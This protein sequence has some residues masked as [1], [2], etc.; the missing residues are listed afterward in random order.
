MKKMLCSAIIILMIGV[1]FTQFVSNFGRTN[2]TEDNMITGEN[3]SIFLSD[4]VDDDTSNANGAGAGKSGDKEFTRSSR[5]SDVIK[6]MFDDAHLPAFSVDPA[7]DADDVHGWGHVG[8]GGHSSF[9][10]VLRDP[11]GMEAS[12]PGH[13]FETENTYE[14]VLLNEG[15]LFTKEV[16]EDIDVL[17]VPMT[18]NGNYRTSEIDVIEDFVKNGGGLLLGADHSNFPA[19]VND[20]AMRFFVRWGSDVVTD[21]NDYTGPYNYWVIYEDNNVPGDDNMPTNDVPGY[22]NDPDQIYIITENAPTVQ[23][24]CSNAYTMEN[25]AESRKIIITDT[26]GSSNF[27]GEPACLAI[28]NGNCTGAGRAVFVPDCN[29]FG[30]TYDCDEDG[31]VDFW[32]EHNAEFGLGIIDWLAPRAYEVALISGEKDPYTGLPKPLVYIYEPGETHTFDIE[33]WNLGL[34]ADTIKLE[35]PDVPGNWTASLDVEETSELDTR[36]SEHITLTVTAPL[37]NVT[38]GDY[39]IINVT[40]TSTGDPENATD[41]IWTTN[42]IIVDLGYNVNWA[43]KPDVNEQKK[44]IVDPGKTTVATLGINNIGNINDTYKI[45]MQGVPSDWKVNVDTDHNPDWIFDE[46][47]M[48]VSNIKLSSY[49]FEENTTGVTVFI[50]PPIDAKEGETAIVTAVGESY[51]SKLS[52]QDAK[53]KHDDEIIFEVSAFRAMEIECDDAIKYVD[54][55]KS[56]TFLIS[57][58]NN[59]NSRE[60]VEIQL[61]PM[62]SGW[63]SI[64]DMPTI[65]LQ[66]RQKKTITVTMT[67]PEGA[68]EGSRCVLEVKL[69]MPSVDKVVDSVFLTTIVNRFCMISASLEDSDYYSLNAG[70][71]ISLNISVSNLGNGMTGANFYMLQLAMG[72]DFD[73][74]SEGLPVDYITLEP[75]QS[76][77]LRLDITVSTKALADGIPETPGFDPYPVIINISGEENF[78]YLFLSILV[79]RKSSIEVFSSKDLEI[80]EPGAFTLFRVCVRNDGNAWDEIQLNIKDIPL[81]IHPVTEMRKPWTVFFSGVSLDEQMSGIKDFE[82]TDFTQIVDVAKLDHSTAFEPS[83]MREE[84][85]ILNE[86]TLRIPMKGAAWVTLTVEVPRYA[87]ARDASFNISSFCISSPGLKLPVIRSTVSVRNA[88]LTFVGGIEL[89]ETI[90]TGQLVSVM[91]SVKNTGDIRAEDVQVRLYVDGQ[92]VATMPIRTILAGNTQMVAF[93]WKVPDISECRLKVVVD[94]DNLIVEKDK[95]DNSIEEDV[96]IEGSSGVMS[97]I[98]KWVMAT[99]GIIVLGAVLTLALMWSIRK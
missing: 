30:D 96:S 12:H 94:P 7:N 2:D 52:G 22:E 34:R 31:K 17:V 73:F 88:A 84:L 11:K 85:L 82:Y 86:I 27:N 50:T 14:V 23:Y 43:V 72:W 32:D 33:V 37:T 78:E 48:S 61:G 53:G 54:P 42:V 51:L 41:T 3:D 4:I 55:G 9:A 68:L 20:I 58:K 24:Y 40:A 8:E 75:Y 90:E 63:T 46:T 5:D 15:E 36:E 67:A 83:N 13:T 60:N 92:A 38:D 81:D 79:S 1:I 64:V 6:V 65:I 10:D 62:I 45:N 91:A 57:V 95:Q 39:A 28:P 77:N 56:V 71:K 21:V 35:I 98:A 66:A 49:H 19:Q 18:F 69:N 59:G 97:G 16:L 44:I 87:S 25:P 76:V 93:T 29:V 47:D 26:D 99:V 80:T 70:D 74:F 89:P